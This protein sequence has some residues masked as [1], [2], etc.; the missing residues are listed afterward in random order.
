M[1]RFLMTLVLLVVG[2]SC[3]SA[4]TIKG[5]Y[6]EDGAVYE[7]TWSHYP[8]KDEN[9]VFSLSEVQEFF[10]SLGWDEPI[11][12][13]SVDDYRDAVVDIL[14]HNN[15]E[16]QEDNNLLEVKVIGGDTP[17]QMYMFQ[18]DEVCSS[19]LNFKDGFNTLTLARKL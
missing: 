9:G 15:I 8:T 5:K 3:L 2:V 13:G 12:M 17:L 19:A 10:K 7:Y 4:K 1:K 18:I 16:Y 14:V 6:Y 11:A